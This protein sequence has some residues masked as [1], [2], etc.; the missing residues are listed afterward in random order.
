[1]YLKF[2]VASVS[3]ELISGF[4]EVSPSC[5]LH[6]FCLIY[7]VLLDIVSFVEEILILIANNLYSYTFSLL[8]LKFYLINCI[9]Y[10]LESISDI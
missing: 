7:I 10:I 8:Y 3:S 4:I 1:M 6:T 9:K 5:I 2:V